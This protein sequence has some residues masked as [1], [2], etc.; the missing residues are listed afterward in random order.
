M[1]Y[2]VSGAS[3]AGKTII[4]RKALEQKQIPYLSLDTLVMGFTNGI[5]EYGIHDRL[6]PAEIAEKIWSFLKAMCESM[7]WAEID[8]MIEGEAILPGLV[9]ELLD[10][11][12]DK[13]RLCFVGYIDV[14]TGAKLRDIRTHSDGTGDW[15]TTE[16]DDFICDH[17]HNMVEHSR[18]IKNDCEKYDLCYFDT[19]T[20]FEGAVEQ[21]TRHLFPRN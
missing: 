13:I 3:R 16:P 5:P 20:D 14:D 9:R 17:I 18:R 11:Y 6:L 12:P 10:K 19:S 15:L 8:Y 1:L 21:A 2:L 7:L 4:A